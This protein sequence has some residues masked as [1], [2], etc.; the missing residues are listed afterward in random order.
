[1]LKDLRQLQQVVRQQQRLAA[2]QPLCQRL[3][4]LIPPEPIPGLDLAQARLRWTMP[5]R[6]G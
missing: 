3:R 6:P 2:L 1:M 5:V 4:L